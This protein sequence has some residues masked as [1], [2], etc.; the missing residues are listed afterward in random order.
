MP[1]GSWLPDDVNFMD[2]RTKLAKFTQYPDYA[3]REDQ[4]KKWEEEYDSACLAFGH[5]DP[6]GSWY[7]DEYYCEPGTL[8]AK[9]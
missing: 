7:G 8:Y 1:N 2:A 3:E 5:V 6:M 9:P 4:N